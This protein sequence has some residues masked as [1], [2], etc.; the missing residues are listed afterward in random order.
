MK[1]KIKT[2]P[3]IENRQAL[4]ALSNR[5]G[6]RKP[7]KVTEPTTEFGKTLQNLMGKRDQTS[8]I[9]E[10]EL[11]AGTVYQLVKNRFG[12]DLAGDFKSA[13]QLNLVDKPMTERASSAE[14]AAKDT[15]KFLVSSTLLS[16]DDARSIRDTAFSAAQIDDT[17]D[18]LW[19]SIGETRAVTSVERGARIVQKRLED[20]GDNPIATTAKAASRKKTPEPET[21]NKMLSYDKHP[22]LTKD[23]IRKALKRSA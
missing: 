18:F 1:T 20:S 2:A 4:E 5:K 9:N 13:Y 22:G 11:F 21:T 12:N 10:E 23:T 7:S 8:E 17:S 14:R 3:P 6:K 16:R 15:L 19:D